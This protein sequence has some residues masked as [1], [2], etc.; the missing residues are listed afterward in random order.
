MCDNEGIVLVLCSQW[1]N[2]V[3]WD[4]GRC[5]VPEMDRRLSDTSIRRHRY[6]TLVTDATPARNFK[7]SPYF[8][9]E[10]RTQSSLHMTDSSPSQ[11][12]ILR[13]LVSHMLWP[14]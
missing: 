7:I 4:G 13:F 10:A 2:R 3:M 12:P 8:Q 14:E 9:A 1:G 6:T 11:H 5:W